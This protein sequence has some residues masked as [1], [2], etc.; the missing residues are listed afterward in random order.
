M[1][2]ATNGHHP[3]PS[4]YLKTLVPDS[5]LPRFDNLRLG[6]YWEMIQKQNPSVLRL[7]DY[8]YDWNGQR[9]KYFRSVWCKNTIDV[10]VS[11]NGLIWEHVIVNKVYSDTWFFK[12]AKRL[13]TN[14]GNS[15]YGQNKEID[16]LLEK[17]ICLS[18]KENHIE[19]KKILRVITND[20]SSSVN[21]DQLDSK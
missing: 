5:K 17:L 18:D 20:Q 11:H 21:T 6:A 7:I 9:I 2:S 14:D 19:L 16:Q 4:W 10:C 1:W 15:K 8:A 13:L 3:G 12:N